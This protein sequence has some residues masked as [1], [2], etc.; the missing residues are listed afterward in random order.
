MSKGIVV[1]ETGGA[2]CLLWESIDPGV[3]GSGQVRVAVAAAGVNFID[4]YFRSGQYVRP[5]PFAVGLEGAGVIE[6][7][8]AEVSDLG[9]GDRVAWSTV[10]GSYACLR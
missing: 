5:L 3:P 9:V 10:P 8:G 4:V 1:R 7:V 6:A 2:D